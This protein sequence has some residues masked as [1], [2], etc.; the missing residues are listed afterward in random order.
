MIAGLKK[1]LGEL[2]GKR[3]ANRVL[4]RWITAIINHLY[5][6]VT[7]TDPHSEL[8]REWWTSVTDHICNIH[9]YPE[10]SVYKKCL[11]RPLDVIVKDGEEYTREWIDKGKQARFY[12]HFFQKKWYQSHVQ[13]PNSVF[14]CPASY[15]LSNSSRVASIVFWNTF[16]FTHRK[17]TLVVIESKALILESVHRR[18]AF[19]FICTIHREFIAC[20]IHIYAGNHTARIYGLYLLQIANSVLFYQLLRLLSL[21]SFVH[22][23]VWWEKTANYRRYRN[24]CY[25]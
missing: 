19:N 3:V 13:T 18:K 16:I 21:A 17:C 24:Y 5:E 1:K 7:H 14:W 6:V 23:N 2:A 8:R 15:A 11:H 25:C 4:G 12:W 20:S 10:N 22:S 9:E